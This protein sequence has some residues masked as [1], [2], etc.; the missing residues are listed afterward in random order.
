MSTVLRMCSLSLVAVLLSIALL[1]TGVN[2]YVGEA[3]SLRNLEIGL[4]EGFIASA[5]ERQ[6]CK[7][8]E[9]KNFISNVNPTPQ[10]TIKNNFG[11]FV[12]VNKIAGQILLSGFVQYS[13][14][15]LS[16][17]FRYRKSDIVFPFQYFW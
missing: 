11:E 10:F 13:A 5:N 4:H 8:V 14:N 2:T 15:T 17:P 6:P 7:A 16:V 3:S 1:A 12:I 9:T